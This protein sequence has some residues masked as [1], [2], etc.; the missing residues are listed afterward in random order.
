[1]NSNSEQGGRSRK[2]LIIGLAVVAI[3]VVASVLFFLIPSPNPEEVARKW[4]ADNVDAAGE[5]LAEFVLDSLGQ[6]GIQ[7]MVLKE[8]GG[9]WIE[10]RINEHLA[11]EFSSARPDGNGNHIVVATA[12]VDFQV[13]QPPVSGNIRAALPFSLVIRGSDVVEDNIMLADAGFDA[14][15]EGIELELNPA[16][17][18]EG[19]EKAEEAVGEAADKLKGLLGN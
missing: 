2:W 6:E 16:N 5:G 10:D 8:L 4:A 17:L 18:E 7:A 9:E 3:A 13:D 1:M 12:S 15:L 14:N 19:V 11:W